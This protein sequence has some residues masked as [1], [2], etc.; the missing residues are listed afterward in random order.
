[1]LPNSGEI[2]VSGEVIRMTISL[3]TSPKQIKKNTKPTSRLDILQRMNLNIL[4]TKYFN[5]LMGCSKGIR[6][7][8]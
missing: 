7:R 1:M 3:L 6:I 2:N 4:L 8:L 5:I